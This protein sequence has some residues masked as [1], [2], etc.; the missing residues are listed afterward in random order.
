MKKTVEKTAKGKAA[1]A[2]KGII[3]VALS[4][5]A[6]NGF[7]PRRNADG[8]SL[9]ELAKSIG[10]VGVLQ[11]ILVRPR[12]KRY[13]I[14]CGERRF[15]ASAMAGRKTVPVT[16][17]RLSDN[18][19]FLLA[20]TEN[21][22]RK[23]VTPMEEAYAYKRLTDTGRYDAASLAARF[24]KSE[25]YI[26]SRLKLNSLMDEI[27]EL[28]NRNVLPV[29]AAL[30]IC[31][32]GGE[33]QAEIYGKH[34]KGDAMYSDWRDLTA[35][36]FARRLE[37]T[38]SNS[39]D[40]YRFD[41][42]QCVHCPFNT[43]ACNLF[44]GD[45]EKG[46]CTN[47]TCLRE[48]NREYLM[49][50]CKTVLDDYPDTEVYADTCPDGNGD[51]FAGLEE[52]GYTVVTD[53][54]FALFPENP[55]VPRRE[56]FDTD[57]EFAQAREK[58]EADVAENGEINR[59]LSEG[60]VNWAVTVRDNRVVAGYTVIRENGEDTEART[61]P[62]PVQKLEAQDRRNRE[63]A[64]EKIVED[65]RQLIGRAEIPQ[66]GFT[67]MEDRFLYFAMLT[68][69]KREHFPLFLQDARDRRHLTDEDKIAITG[70]LTEEGK[71][72]IRRDFLVKHLSE[73]FG[74]A[75]KS[76]LMIEFARLHFPD[77]VA[78][79][80]NRHNEVYGKRH[81]RIT[82]R[83]NALQEKTDAENAET[84]EDAGII[85]KPRKERIVA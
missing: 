81:R 1:A 28:V 73:T 13:E 5:I 18:E 50:E 84:V 70:Q 78:E 2:A 66:S 20:V 8:D 7:N 47:P 80:E 58:Y 57:G 65:T 60:K 61:V 27:T 31:K 29:T 23:D 79:I 15:R 55:I 22:H 85:E 14:V 46:K 19:A 25:K 52:Q 41:K 69:L 9:E 12:G 56:E 40:R 4:K 48:K 54:C 38:Y 33:T 42:A 77:K 30:E 76:Y 62:D 83:L 44:N 49:A 6:V 53:G 82:E 3:A 71:T 37:K 63:I 21:L 59:L 16:V 67:E 72:V 36:E 43:D 26:R 64:V 34:L 17:R 32:Y 10:Q 51:V 45:A 75:K 11:P 68:D 35:R 74:T 39:L 24:G